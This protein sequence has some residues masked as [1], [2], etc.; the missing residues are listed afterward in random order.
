MAGEVWAS[1][2][3]APVMG[4]IPKSLRPIAAGTVASAM[5]TANLSGKPGVHI[6]GSG[7]MQASAAR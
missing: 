7:A 2:L 6:L 4:L 1:R 3:L 5:L